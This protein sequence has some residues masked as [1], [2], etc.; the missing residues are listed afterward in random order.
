MSVISIKQFQQ[1]KVKQ[2]RTV[3]SKIIGNGLS[4]TNLNR[5]WRCL[6]ENIRTE[7]AG[8]ALDRSGKDDFRFFFGGAFF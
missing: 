4:R 6:Y 8:L 5:D 1:W 3:K 7:L 2:R